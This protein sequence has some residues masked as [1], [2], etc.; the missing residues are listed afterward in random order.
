MI[1]TKVLLFVSI[2]ATLGTG[3]R[4]NAFSPRVAAKLPLKMVSPAEGKNSLSKAGDMLNTMTSKVLPS[5][6]LAAGLLS[7]APDADAVPSG[8]RTGGSS[9]SRGGSSSYSY[10]SRPS[11]RI[12]SYNSYSSTT[13]IPVPTISPF[14]VYSPFSFGF[15]G[16]YSPFALF[17]PN[18]IILGMV[19]Y[20]AYQLLKSR[21]GGAD[22]S[23]DGDAGSLG[24]GATVL[25]LQLALDSDWADDNNIMNVLSELG[26][27]RGSRVNDRAELASLL[28]D[29]S[30]ALLRREGSWSAAS[31]RGERFSGSSKA[32][33]FFQRTAVTERSKFEKENTG[34]NLMRNNLYGNAISQG[35][36]TQAVVSIVCAI[37][38]RSDALRNVRSARDIK[39]ALQTL[40]SEA[41]TDDGENVMA[42][43]VMWTPSDANEVLSQRDIIVDYPELLQL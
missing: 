9:F 20:A 10:S 21:V 30:I 31:I 24:S 37:R 3:F 1:A 41:L 12:N 39:E 25:T 43:E 27:R 29:A 15:G 5:L 26:S 35:S 8:G 40:A 42:V 19:A 38:G 6:M 11:T 14:P 22:F 36:R 28:S 7:F 17:N 33:P 4:F 18:V 34:S 23:N 2:C 13:V 32:E 16:F